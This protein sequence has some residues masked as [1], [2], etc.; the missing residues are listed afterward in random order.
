MSVTR[1]RIES[2]KQKYSPNSTP[3]DRAREKKDNLDEMILR[4]RRAVNK[5]GILH[6]WKKKEFYEKPSDKRRRERRQRIR[7]EQK[8][9]RQ[10]NRR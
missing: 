8:H 2:R 10:N 5:A 7:E 4:L 6:D 9:N 1:V 3:Q